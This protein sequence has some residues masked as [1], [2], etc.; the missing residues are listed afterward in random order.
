MTTKIKV[1]VEA[2]DITQATGYITGLT[3]NEGNAGDG[4]GITD[5]NLS[6]WFKTIAYSSLPSPTGTDPLISNDLSSNFNK[7]SYAS[8]DEAKTALLSDTVNT[9]TTNYVQGTPT[10]SLD[11]GNLIVECFFADQDSLN[12]WSQAV[13]SFGVWNVNG[14]VISH[15]S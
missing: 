6:D 1:K 13:S 8:V 10:Y 9:A 14:V 11:S 2:Y 12:A 5:E 7:I 3:D 15:I 4:V